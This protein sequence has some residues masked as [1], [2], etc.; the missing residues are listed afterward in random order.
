MKFV[1]SGLSNI[2]ACASPAAFAFERC[3]MAAENMAF[4]SHWN[5]KWFRAWA[6]CF[7]ALKQS[8]INRGKYKDYDCTYLLSVNFEILYKNSETKV[9]FAIQ[10]PNIQIHA[11]SHAWE[12]SPVFLLYKNHHHRGILRPAHTRNKK[13]LPLPWLGFGAVAMMPATEL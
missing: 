5:E 3:Q 10:W 11:N 2:H 7:H 13:N 6:Q 8:K 1:S 9:D 12:Q 4:S